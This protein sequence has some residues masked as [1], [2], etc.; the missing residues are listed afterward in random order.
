MQYLAKKPTKTLGILGAGTEAR[1]HLG[2]FHHVFPSLERIFIWSRRHESCTRLID[3]QKS[4]VKRLMTL[5]N[6]VKD[7]AGQSDVICTVTMAT[8]PVLFGAHIRNGT[9]INGEYTTN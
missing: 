9:H 7:A 4:E 8:E 1:S 3:E 2:A 6:D 5:C